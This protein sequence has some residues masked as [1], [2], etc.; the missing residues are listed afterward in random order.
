MR[1]SNSWREYLVIVIGAL[2][3]FVLNSRLSPA[4]MDAWGWRVPFL[5]GA[6]IAPI[7]F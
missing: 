2:F 7:G 1:A 3:A 6:V 4:S 5:F